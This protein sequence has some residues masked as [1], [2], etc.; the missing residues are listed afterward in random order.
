VG[1]VTKFP[2]YNKIMQTSTDLGSQHDAVSVSD[3]ESDNDEDSIADTKGEP[4]KAKET[5]KEMNKSVSLEK[6][7]LSKLTN[8]HAKSIFKIKEDDKMS[9]IEN[10]IARN[11]G[12]PI[13]VSKTDID[14]NVAHNQWGHHGERRLK[15][16]ASVY[17]F[18]LT[19]KLNPCDA[20]G[21]AKACQTRISKSTKIQATMPG[22]RLF[23]DTTGPFSECLLNHKYLHGAVDDFSGKMFA[24][25]SGT[26]TQMTQVAEKVIKRCEGEKKEVKYIRI[27]GG[28]ENKGVKDL[29]EE[30][31]G[32][33]I[34]KTPPHTPQY[35]GRIERRFTIII[36]MA[37]AML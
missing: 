12:N 29:V 2:V 11:D 8:I 14:M 16:M 35:N 31:G 22:E 1:D 13:S 7:N 4:V 15:E 6:D 25:F 19:G 24:R 26:K 9:E 23:I 21:I 17:G 10:A 28:G 3:S 30:M 18:R 20:C 36:S 27:D 32:I 34:E 5:I 37:M 33:T